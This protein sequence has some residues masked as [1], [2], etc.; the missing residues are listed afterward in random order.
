MLQLTSVA[1]CCCSSWPSA[2]PF[3]M[4]SDA[5]MRTR[6]CDLHSN[7]RFGLESHLS[8]THRDFELDSD[9]CFG[10]HEQSLFFFFLFWC[11]NIE[12]TLKRL[13]S[14]MWFLPFF[15]GNY[16]NH[17][18]HRVRALGPHALV[19]QMTT[20]VTGGTAAAAAVPFVITFGYEN[21]KQDGNKTKGV[22]T[23]N[24]AVPESRMLDPPH[25]ILSGTGKLTRIG[26][27]H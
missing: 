27:S 16:G 17:I 24:S 3:F 9:S 20:M 21:I 1:N 26:Q 8:R 12:G 10:T 14:L 15:H 4:C 6:V 5:E 13:M 22:L 7:L 11:I 19:P 23:V 25:H 18:T 2:F